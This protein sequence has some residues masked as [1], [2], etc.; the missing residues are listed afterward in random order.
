MKP[1]VSYPSTRISRHSWRRR[2][3]ISA[4]YRQKLH[5]PIASLVEEDEYVFVNPSPTPTATHDQNVPGQP[6]GFDEYLSDGDGSHTPSQETPAKADDAHGRG[7]RRYLTRNVMSTPE[8]PEPSALRPP[9]PGAHVA[10]KPGIPSLGALGRRLSMSI[11]R[12]SLSRPHSR[13]ESLLGADPSK[14]KSRLSW[15]GSIRRKIRGHGRRDSILDSTARAEEED[16]VD[17]ACAES[18]AGDAQDEGAAPGKDA[19]TPPPYPRLRSQPSLCRSS[20]TAN[21]EDVA[22]VPDTDNPAAKKPRTPPAAPLRQAKRR[23]HFLLPDSSVA[24]T[25]CSPRVSSY[26]ALKA[27]EYTNL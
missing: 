14:L 24:S 27:R 20:R 21:A 23:S 22:F 7:A 6:R 9:P 18:V 8:P 25:T 26:N 3:T 12:P 4:G 10:S 11:G 16:V 15:I 5:S 1:L 13:G 17:E 19:V 2:S